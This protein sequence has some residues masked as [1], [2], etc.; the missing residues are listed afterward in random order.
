MAVAMACCTTAVQAQGVL[1]RVKGGG[2]IVI[3]HRESSVPFSYVD[4]VSRKPV[5]YALDLCLKIAE[6]VGITEDEAIR[7]TQVLKDA[8]IV[9]QVS[10]IFD[11]SSA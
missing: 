7:R 10:A 5:G 3:A 2:K 9:R 4:P 1:E 11:N 8:A 6:A